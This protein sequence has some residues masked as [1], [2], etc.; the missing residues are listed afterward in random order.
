MKNE[1]DIYLEQIGQ[2][3]FEEHGTRGYMVTAQ[4]VFDAS[5]KRYTLEEIQAWF[6]AAPELPP[7]PRATGWADPFFGS[8][9]DVK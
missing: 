5:D 3:V 2:Q 7:L 1:K 8:G 4:E 6:D 9:F